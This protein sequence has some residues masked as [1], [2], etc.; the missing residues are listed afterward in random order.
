MKTCR[1][2][3]LSVQRSHLIYADDQV[4]ISPVEED[5]DAKAEIRILIW[6]LTA[7]IEDVEY[8]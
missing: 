4:V 7:N 1:E 3:G 2:I 5:Y 6:G 8:S